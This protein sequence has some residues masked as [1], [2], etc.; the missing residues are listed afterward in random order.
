LH[1]VCYGFVF[2]GAFLY[3]EK[4]APPD[5][6][7]SAQQVYAIIILGAGPILAGA[8]NQI[9]DR[10]KTTS[11]AQDYHQ[12]WWA[13]AAVSIACAV[14]LILFFPRE[15]AQPALAGAVCS[16]PGCGA[17]NR[18]GAQVCAACGAPLGIA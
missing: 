10:F 3:V 7:H 4:V 9:F 15:S 2:A 16:R 1:G 13:D 18:P 14:A 6:R 17:N 8:Y 11:G 5:A 12:F